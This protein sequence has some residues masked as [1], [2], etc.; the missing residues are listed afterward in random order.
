MGLGKKLKKLGGKV[1]NVGTL[2]LLGDGPLSGDPGD[3]APG[4][5]DLRFLDDI[6]KF[7]FLKN[8]AGRYGAL[9]DTPSS[10]RFLV[11]PSGLASGAAALG[12]E[13]DQ[14]F[15]DYLGA[16]QA[17]SSVDEVMGQI[18]D[19]SLQQLLAGIDED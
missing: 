4:A 12:A 17:P 18:D 3:P 8:S 6:S 13:G 11:D 19:E 14:A 16:I 9:R 10:N 1:L 5:P 7:D 15:G 2:G